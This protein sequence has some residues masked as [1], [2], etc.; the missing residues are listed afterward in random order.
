MTDHEPPR[1]GATRPDGAQR[2][3]GAPPSRKACPTGGT[4]ATYRFSSKVDS[5]HN[6]WRLDEYLAHR[7]RYHPKAMWLDRLTGGHIWLNGALGHASDVVLA[8]DTVEY[9][10]DVVEPSVDFA[11]ETVYQDDDIVVVSKSGNIPVHASGRYVRHTLIARVR[12]DFTGKLDLAHRLD[13]ETS[14]LVVL[15]RNKA[16]ARALGEAF[17]EG[18]VEKRYIAV[19]HGVPVADTFTVSAPLRKIGKQHPIPRAVVDAIAGKPA[20]TDVRVLERLAGLSVLEARPH[21][22]RT[23]QVRVHLEISGH[24]VVGDKTYGLPAHLLRRMVAD[25]DDPEVRAHLVLPR[26]ALHHAV[27]RFAHPRTGRELALAAPLAPDIVSFIEAVG[28]RTP[29]D[30]AQRLLDGTLPAPAPA[31]GGR[32]TPA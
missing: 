29:P 12:E 17:R 3:D 21:T 5:F 4:P 28:G 1:G 6:G 25:P 9:Q 10:F 20:R 22:G 23:N 7:F 24:P 32:P 26:H 31:G 19:V 18:R 16:A 8:G 14:G 27:M 13:R 15:A 30:V 2:P 11:Y